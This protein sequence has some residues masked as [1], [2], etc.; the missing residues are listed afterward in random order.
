VILDGL[1]LRISLGEHTAV[2]G[3]NGSGKTSLIRLITQQYRPLA[4]PE[5]R[6]PV[7][8]FGRDR[9]DVLELR[10]LLGI[11]SP[12]VD[13]DFGDE[14]LTAGACGMDAVISGFF[15]SPGIR[16]YDVV[17]GAMQSRAREVLHL[18]EAS[19]LAG[20]RVSEMST[21]EERRVLIARALVSDPPALLLDE[22]TAGLDI[23]ARGFFLEMLRSLARR[24]TTIILVTH[25]VDEIIPE[26]CRVILL[27]DGKIVADGT[28]SEVLASTSLSAAFGAP[29]RVQS[30]RGGYFTV[31]LDSINRPR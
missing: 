26:V 2:L 14:L 19:H 23:V 27:R 21:G 7:Q 31:V 5:S 22:P 30:A 4:D 3:P 24:G 12:D 15:A 10:K 6:S 9:W 29:L 25:H 18:L 16:P 13:R 11:V 8:I 1:D 20:K 17:T 28:K